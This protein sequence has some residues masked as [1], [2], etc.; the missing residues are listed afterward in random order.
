MAGTDALSRNGKGALYQYAVLY[1]PKQT[2]D[3]AERNEYPKSVL[4]V[5][6]VR[7]VAAS[8]DEVGMLA[9]RDIPNDYIDK[10]AD[11]EVVVSPF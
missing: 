5:A 1:H 9:A 3:Q 6:P 8:P 7:V 10:L 2:K 11:C 4:I